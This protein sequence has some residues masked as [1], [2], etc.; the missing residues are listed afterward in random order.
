M[1]G[2]NVSAG[3]EGLE[4]EEG[5]KGQERRTLVKP[6]FAQGFHAARCS[7]ARRDIFTFGCLVF[8]FLFRGQNP[9]PFSSPWPSTGC[10]FRSSG[11]SY[12]DSPHP[13]LPLPLHTATPPRRSFTVCSTYTLMLDRTTRIIYLRDLDLQPTARSQD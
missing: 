5:G 12:P 3:G 10:R 13:L 9:L 8:G 11:H 1:W 7:R 2:G 6:S 4:E